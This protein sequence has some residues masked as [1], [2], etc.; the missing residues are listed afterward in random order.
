VTMQMNDENLF[1]LS[2]F[3]Y[4]YYSGTWESRSR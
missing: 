2:Q 4:M 1:S 3:D